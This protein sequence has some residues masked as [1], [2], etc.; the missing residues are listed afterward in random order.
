MR[1]KIDI[2][3]KEQPVTLISGIT[4]AQVPYWFPFYNYKDLKMDI[5]APSGSSSQ[6][7]RPLFV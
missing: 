5:L 3:V 2:P 6:G 1:Y 4:F 7:K